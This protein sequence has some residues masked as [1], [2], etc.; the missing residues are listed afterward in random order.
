MS[1]L[2]NLM[3]QCFTSELRMRR[4]IN[5]A[6]SGYVAAFIAVFT[7]ACTVGPDF[8]R[9]GVPA[10]ASY[11]L[12]PLD[13][14]QLRAEDNRQS[15][16]WSLFHS[17]ALDS[18]MQQALAG[19]HSLAGAKATLAEALETVKASEG[20][21]F[22]HV[23][24]DAGIGRQQYGAEFSGPTPVVP[25]TYFSI[26]PSVSYLLDYAGGQHRA[27]EHQRALADMQGYEVQAAYLSLTGNVAQQALAIA[28]ARAQSA[29]VQDLLDNDKTNVSLVQTA[30]ENGAGTRVDLLSAQ[31][32]LAGDQALLP[33]LQQKLSIARHA[34]SILV[35]E[36]PADW[37]PPDFD[38]DTLALPDTLPRTLPAELAHRRPDILAA[39]ARLHAATAAEGVAIANLYP[40]INLAGSVTQQSA[41]LSHWLDASGTAWGL[42]AGL[43][44]PLFDGG[45][46][47]AQRRAAHGAR[48]AAFDDYQQTVLRAFGQVA[49]VLTALE[50][51]A[52]QFDAQ[53]RAIDLAD[54]NL[55]L[56]RESYSAGNI[57]VLQLLDAERLLQ[58]ATLG[59]VNARV[60][61]YQDTAQLFLALGGNTRDVV[62]ATPP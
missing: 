62:A 18:T 5:C 37:S 54:S 61:R 3:P 45:T 13:H 47:S 43:T 58:R 15:D 7:S 10:P 26:G 9:P 32:Q 41:N 60:Q 19:N 16:W 48:Q 34:L 44:A 40:Q 23:E 55:N 50:H 52:E 28:S 4:R 25:F 29:A 22:P 57:G 11:T 6:C 20:P 42:A 17:A 35:G 21:L 51:D 12:E 33:P 2:N 24:V 30:F 38:L 39:E 8:Q 46:L 36:A 49:D 31:S 59:Y 14:L 27:V 1:Q 53:K 56:A